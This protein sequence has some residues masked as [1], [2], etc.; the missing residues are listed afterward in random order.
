MGITILSNFKFATMLQQI[1]GATVKPGGV[2]SNKNNNYSLYVAKT[3]RPL[4]PVAG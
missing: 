2:Y 4:Y 1:R 3:L